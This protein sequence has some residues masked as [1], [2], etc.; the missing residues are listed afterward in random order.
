[1]SNDLDE[2]CEGAVNGRVPSIVIVD[3]DAALCESL[4]GW[5]GAS[6][7][8][9]CV[10][11]GGA[12]AL[13]QSLSVVDVALVD[14]DPPPSIQAPV[15]QE[16][17]RWPSAICVLMSADAQKVEQLRALGVFA[18]LVLDKPVLQEALEAIRSATLELCRALG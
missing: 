4:A 3:D 7:R 12:V 16:L 13:L 14:C 2:R 9:H 18:P 15:F 11:P 17:A 8:T 10:P 1:M 6:C 5:I